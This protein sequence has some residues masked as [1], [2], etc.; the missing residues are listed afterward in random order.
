MTALLSLSNLNRTACLTVALFALSA[1]ATTQTAP[2]SAASDAAQVTS[3]ASAEPEEELICKMTPVVGSKFKRKLCGTE[4][5]WAAATRL[6][7][8]FAASVQDAWRNPGPQT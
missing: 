5:Q 8:S 6:G 7:R 2:E 4:D 3:Q 1:C